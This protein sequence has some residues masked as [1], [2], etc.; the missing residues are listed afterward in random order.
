M[1]PEERE[2]LA[3]QVGLAIVR[4]RDEAEKYLAEVTAAG[5]EKG[6]RRWSKQLLMLEGHIRKYGLERYEIS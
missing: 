1:S 6:M 4:L 3:D 5:D 2:K